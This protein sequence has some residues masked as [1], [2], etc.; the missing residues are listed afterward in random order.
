MEEAPVTVSPN[1]EKIGERVI[2]SI[3]FNCREVLM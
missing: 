1:R 2:A 3:R